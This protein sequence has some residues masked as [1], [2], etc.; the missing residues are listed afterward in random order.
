VAGD[1]STG[2]G[3]VFPAEA[4]FQQIEQQLACR[5]ELPESGSLFS[6]PFDV[7][8][9][10]DTKEEMEQPH[11]LTAVSEDVAETAKGKGKEITVPQGR[12]G[13]VLVQGMIE[14]GKGT[15]D[16]PNTGR[17]NASP[18]VSPSIEP[19]APHRSA[20]REIFGLM[21]G[22]SRDRGGGRDRDMRRDG[23]DRGRRAQQASARTNE[24]FVPK[25]GIDREV[26]TADICRYLG[27]DALVRPGNYEVCSQ[28]A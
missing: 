24:Y 23:R 6:E 27:N 11:F 2:L 10:P 16:P 19:S 4:V 13:A 22:S 26:I 21:L 25:D 14:K 8:V 15:I 1:L 5:I 3:Y 9:D 20:N 12:E 28:L 17:D 18:R 7:P